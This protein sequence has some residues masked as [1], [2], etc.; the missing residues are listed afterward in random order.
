MLEFWHG[1]CR[2]NLDKFFSALWLT[3][4]WNLS[5]HTVKMSVWAL[6]ANSIINSWN[7]PQSTNV[8][9]SP[10]RQMSRKP[11]YRRWS[12]NGIMFNN[13]AV[14]NLWKAVVNRFIPATDNW[15]HPIVDWLRSITACSCRRLK[16]KLHYFDLLFILF[17]T[18][19]IANQIELSGV[20]AQL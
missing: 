2:Q 18:C 1:D 9:R 6:P 7:D 20:W 19:C 3:F 8:S 15:L 13:R 14:V 16:P 10:Q 4:F 12:N 17:T 11:L 5:R